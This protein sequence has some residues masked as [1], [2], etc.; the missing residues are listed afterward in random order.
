MALSI[1][2]SLLLAPCSCSLLSDLTPLVTKPKSAN[3]RTFA[4]ISARQVEAQFANDLHKDLYELHGNHLS[5]SEP[6][7]RR[8]RH[9]VQGRRSSLTG[10]SIGCIVVLEC[11]RDLLCSASWNAAR[12]LFTSRVW[13]MS[14]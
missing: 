10:G 7:T 12:G 5:S 8:A 2:T 13:R 1:E 6:K 14:V 9:A 3:D 4:S 11:V